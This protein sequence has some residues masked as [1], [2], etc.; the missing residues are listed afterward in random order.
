MRLL[1]NYIAK[2]VLSSVL[3]VLVVLLGVESFLELAAELRDVGKGHYNI[4]QALLMVPLMLPTD[5]YQLFPVAALIGSLLGLGKLANQSELIVMLAAGVSKMQIIRAL[6]KVTIILLLIVSIS[7][8]WLA[9]YTQHRARH[10]KAIALS[11][12]QTLS[13]NSGVW[14]RDGSNFIFIRDILMGNELRDITRYA[15]DD[16]KKLHL[17]SHADRG[18]YQ[19]GRWIFEHV[20]QSRIFDDHITSQYFPL[21]E[22]NISL[23][24]RLLGISNVKPDQM[25]LTKLHSFITFRHQNGLDAGLY[26]FEFWKRLLQPFATVVMIFLAVPFIFGPLRTVSM[27]LRILSGVIV[28]FGFYIMNQ[29][30]GPL[31]LVYQIPAFLAAALPTILFAFLGSFLLFLKI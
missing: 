13:T 15:F 21:Q 7:G 31:S 27:G 3:L 26:E 29:F 19:Q 30:F 17:A 12:G 23:D 18:A 22:W 10:L 6:L 11:S 14:F 20:T 16:A 2:V 1:S 5:I 8:A 24:K 9:P 25:S 4:T 28:G